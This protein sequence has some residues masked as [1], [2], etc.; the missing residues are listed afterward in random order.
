MNYHC[1]SM[2]DLTTSNTKENFGRAGPFVNVQRIYGINLPNTW[3]SRNEHDCFIDQQVEDMLK[4][5]T[6]HLS[7]REWDFFTS[8][9]GMGA[10]IYTPCFGEPV[11]Q[12]QYEPDSDEDEYHYQPTWASLNPGRRLREDG[13]MDP[14]HHLWKKHE[15]L[16]RMLVCPRSDWKYPEWN[17]DHI[18]GYRGR[19]RQEMVLWRHE[20]GDWRPRWVEN[21]W[22][23]FWDGG[24]YVGTGGRKEDPA[25][26]VV[27]SRR[28]L[29]ARAKQCLRV[30]RQSHQIWKEKKTKLQQP[31]ITR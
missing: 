24:R 23:V 5:D 21:T 17:G 4:I 25:T 19:H 1:D 8:M 9:L 11:D 10:S 7:D 27:Y 22:I 16:E 30:I 26:V 29:K 2:A 15:D 12:P 6:S 13:R 20:M 3:T 31:D 28:K 18:V 14:R